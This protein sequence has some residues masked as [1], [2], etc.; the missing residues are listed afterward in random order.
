M[1]FPG[2]GSDLGHRHKLSLSYSNSRF[3][4]HS[5]RPGIEPASQRSQDAANLVVP[6]Q[7]LQSSILKRDPTCA[8]Q[9]LSWG[10]M[11]LFCFILFYFLF[12]SA[13]S[14]AYGGS[15]AR[16]QIGAIAAGIHHS[17]GNTRSLTHWARPGMELE[18]SWLLV[19]FVSTEPQRELH[20]SNVFRIKTQF[21]IDT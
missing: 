10:V 20:G 4:T 16:G 1:E 11:F 12:F 2:Q 17:H 3:L 21:R 7:E 13:A 9:S 14:T 15:Q 5:S 19:R 8:F 18:S 6:Q